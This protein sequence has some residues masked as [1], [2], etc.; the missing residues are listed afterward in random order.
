M[1]RTLCLLLALAWTSS[2]AHAEE[3][4]DPVEILKKVD[5]ATRAVKSVKFNVSADGSSARSH[6]IKGSIIMTGYADGAPEKYF[7]ELSVE[8]PDSADTRRVTGGTDHDMYFIVDHK[9]KKA[10]EDLD[11]AVMGSAGRLFRQATMIEFLHEAPFSDEING[12]NQELKGSEKIG[13]EDCYVVYVEYAGV[14]NRS[15]TWSFSKKDFLP[16]RRIDAF[17]S[18]DGNPTTTRKTITELVV[19]PKIDEKVFKVN[20][21]AGYTKTDDFAPNFLSPAR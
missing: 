14:Q 15:A 1:K 2:A 8:L 11:P 17:T 21:P 5:A 4:T 19:D 18:R 20:L 10:Y 13:D 16:R 6:K 12:K 7:F 9:S 3:M